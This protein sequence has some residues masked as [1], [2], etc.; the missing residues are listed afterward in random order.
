MLP[1]LDPLILARLIA[2]TSDRTAGA[3]TLGRRAIRL[4]LDVSQE[5]KKAVESVAVALCLGQPAMAPVWNAAAAA[6]GSGGVDRLKILYGKADRAPQ[7][8]SRVF[9]ELVMSSKSETD[10][11]VPLVFATVSASDSVRICFEVLSERTTIRA[12]CAEGRPR[13]EGR[14]MATT[15]ATAGIATTICTDAAI[16]EAIATSSPQVE[17]VV[18]GADAVAPQW[19]LN[20]CGTRQLLELAVSL[21]F[22][23][24]VVASRDKFISDALAEHIHPGSGPSQEVWD[25]TPRG[26]HAENPYF[27]KIP[28]ELV[29]A[30]ITDVGSIGPASAQDMCQSSV[31]STGA[32]RLGSLLGDTGNR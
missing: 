8:L 13:M 17:A 12:I 21:G 25:D 16:G 3:M 27:E 5:D 19:F 22:P 2:I 1:D 11:A 4:L 26:V 30:F 29:A 24:Y 32:S 15:L 31:V 14:Q 23:A 20:K 9:R 18:V 28:I 6:V 10:V 7:S